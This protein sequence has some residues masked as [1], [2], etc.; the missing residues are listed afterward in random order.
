MAD[1]APDTGA[2][3]AQE[4]RAVFAPIEVA[5]QR[6]TAFAQVHFHLV[7]KDRMY[8]PGFPGEHRIPPGVDARS[9]ALL[10]PHPRTRTLA[11]AAFTAGPRS[12]KDAVSFPAATPDPARVGRS[13]P[14]PHDP[15]AAPLST[16]R[17]VRDHPFR[18]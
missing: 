8:F 2:G 17:P 1:A 14:V 5:R 9:S 18:P 11:S 10:P 6:Q 15:R 13:A 4:R 12:L 16:R 3:L 7:P